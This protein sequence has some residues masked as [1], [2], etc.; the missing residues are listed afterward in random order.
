MYFQAKIKSSMRNYVL[1]SD[2]LS[3]LN[4]RPLE[5][6]V[7]LPRINVVFIGKTGTGKSATANTLMGKTEFEESMSA[8]STSHSIV[9]K[10][11]V[12]G[13]QSFK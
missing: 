13:G 4:S 3:P 7:R 10:E 11:A 12:I 1:S 8:T 2:L 9:V 5:D 6:L